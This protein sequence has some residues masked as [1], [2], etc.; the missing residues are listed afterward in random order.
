VEVRI[1]LI[2]TGGPLE[3]RQFTFTA[4]AAWTIGRASA[5]ALRLPG[6]EAGRAVSRV[7]CRLDVDPPAV[8]VCDLGSLNGTYVN[9]RSIGQ[10]AKGQPP[11]EAPADP[12]AVELHDGDRLEVGNSAFVVSIEC[13]ADAEAAA[14]PR[15]GDL[16][17]CL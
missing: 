2:A 16:A 12:Q 5:C 10:R 4:P 7:H 9:G 1:T 17:A 6:D 11:S 15:Q 14:A 3:G 13:G 8:R